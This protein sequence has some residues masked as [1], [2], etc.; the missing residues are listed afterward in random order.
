LRE[1]R[2]EREVEEE[3]VGVR[4]ALVGSRRRGRVL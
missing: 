3:V 2:T 1:I 4:K